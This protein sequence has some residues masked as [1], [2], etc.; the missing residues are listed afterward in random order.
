MPS[1]IATEVKPR[2]K[3]ITHNS[4][5][6]IIEKPRT[7]YSPQLIKL[8]IASLAPTQKTADKK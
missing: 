2:C 3:L 7:Q 5:L 6:L 1:A 4:A 8:T